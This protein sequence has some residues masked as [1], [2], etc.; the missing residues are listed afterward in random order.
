MLIKQ[1]GVNEDEEKASDYVA[2]HC[3]PN[4]QVGTKILE[5]RNAIVKSVYTNEQNYMLYLEFPAKDYYNQQNALN[6]VLD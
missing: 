1:A 2:M 5:D 3:Y 6:L 4:N